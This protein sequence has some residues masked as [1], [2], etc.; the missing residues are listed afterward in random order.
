MPIQ[1]GAAALI[2]HRRHLRRLVLSSGDLAT[3]RICRAD[4]ARVL[5]D[6]LLQPDALCK[7]FEVFSLPGLP[8]ESIASSLALLPA[9]R[10]DGSPEPDPAAYQ[11]LAQLKPGEKPMGV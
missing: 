11:V 2:C 10:I 4:L 9:D 6:A 8:A 1:C 3:G 7:T 5:V